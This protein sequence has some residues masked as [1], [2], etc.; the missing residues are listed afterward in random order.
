V[1][2][3]YITHQ[4][5]PAYAGG[6]E[7]YT[8]ALARALIERGQQV[9]VLCTADWERG[10]RYWNGHV[11]DVFEGVP[12][13]RLRLNWK[14]A[15][16]VNRYL[17]DNPLV[18]R[19]VRTYLEGG[20]CDVVHVTSCN[21]LSAS[22]IGAAKDAG[23]PVVV[24]LTDFWFVC[25]RGNLVAGGGTLCDGQVAEQECVRCLAFTAKAY[26]WPRRVLGADMAM[27]LL[28]RISKH[29]GLTRVRGLRG[30]AMDIQ[31]RR[32]KVQDALQRADRVLIGAYAARDVFRHNGFTMAIDVV[33][34]GHDLS[35]LRRYGGKAP[36]EVI[37]FGFIGQIAPVK[38]PQLLIAAYK[39]ARQPG[40][41]RLL[42]YGNMEKAREFGEA[43]RRLA[44]G[45]PD[46][47]FRG[48]YPHAKSAEVFEQIDVL[49]VPSLWSDYPLIIGEAFAAQTPVITTDLGGMREFVQPEINGLLFR[50][51]VT[52]DL[53]RQL[54]RVITEPTLLAQLRAG[55]PHVKGMDEAADEMMEIYR[56]M[57]ETAPGPG[58]VVSA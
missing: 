52:D 35:W 20:A 17:Y 4:Y 46:I 53:A 30:M 33:P 10:R 18:G 55:I 39:I 48:T 24:T 51:G 9:Q 47:E 19:Y 16:E 49:V 5:P 7:T 6:T 14:K 37:H 54:R 1:R 29:G 12:V 23:V 28:H 42:V 32:V 25:P 56:R 36:R 8:H 34:Y 50:R 15:P 27:R 13:R 44:G 38:G 43:L 26:R 40:R 31:D 57:I 21:T 58:R 22:V 2:A 11:D 41:T 45:R 3:L